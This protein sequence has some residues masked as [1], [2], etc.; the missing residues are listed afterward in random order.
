MFKALRKEIQVLCNWYG[1][2]FDAFPGID[3]RL[4][5]TLIHYF[6][7]NILRDNPLPQSATNFVMPFKGDG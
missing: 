7:V 4:P 3:V 2:R 5:Y 1:D 6:P